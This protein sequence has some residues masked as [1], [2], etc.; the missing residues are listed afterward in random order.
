[1]P[2]Y[3]VAKVDRSSTS[4]RHSLI[5]RIESFGRQKFDMGRCTPCQNSN[6]LCFILD[7]YSRCSS[8][9]KKGVKY[10]DGTFSVE[11]FDALTAQRNRL[12]EAA[13]QKDEELK[14]MLREAARIQEALSSAN[15]ERERLQRESDE[16]LEKQRRMLVREA[17]A[18]DE[19]DSVDPPPIASSTVFV[20]LGDDQLEDYFEIP[21]GSLSGFEGPIPID[22]PSA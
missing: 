7:G 20:G 8:C 16:L 15:A 3:R 1:M 9:M 18:L 19:L 13:R 4:R 11:E 2:Q 21:R 12:Q 10:C 22:R 6:S 17:E 14:G 5:S